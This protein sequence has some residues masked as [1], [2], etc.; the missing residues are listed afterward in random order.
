MGAFPA[1]VHASRVPAMGSRGRRGRTAVEVVAEQGRR[2]REDPAYR[3]EV[4]R[5]DAKLAERDRQ[6]RSAEQPL[7]ADLHAAGVE[8]DTIWNLYKQPDS[9]PAAIPVLLRHLQL[10]YPA[11]VLEGIASGFAHKAA[12]PWW[13][14][15]KRLYLAAERDVVRDGLAAALSTCATKARYD[16]LLA[17][18]E[19]ERSGSSWRRRQRERDVQRRASVA[20][21]R[22]GADGQREVCNAALIVFRSLVA[23]RSF[24]GELPAP[25]GVLEVRGSVSFDG[26][27][28]D[29]DPVGECGCSIVD[30]VAGSEFVVL[31]EAVHEVA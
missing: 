31:G 13:D 18:V 4:E 26:V 21:T 23:A 9:I 10:D 1:F 15:L 5:F 6:Y 8:I 7:L 30:L 3:A 17:F 25:D 28:D 27:E 20:A 19:N 22:S 2:L 24:V 12:R 11:R 29:F 14:E 16:D